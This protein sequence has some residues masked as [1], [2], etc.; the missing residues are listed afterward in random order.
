MQNTLPDEVCALYNMIHWLFSSC[1]LSRSHLLPLGLYQ[2]TCNPRSKSRPRNWKQTHER[3]RSPRYLDVNQC[4]FISISQT[5]SSHVFILQSF[6]NLS[7]SH[8]IL[9][10]TLCL[11]VVNK[12]WTFLEFLHI[13]SS[14]IKTW[15]TVINPVTRNQGPIFLAEIQVNIGQ[16]HLKILHSFSQPPGVITSPSTYTHKVAFDIRLAAGI[17]ALYC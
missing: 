16:K 17:M 4:F 11:N 1:N 12:Y 14:K 2:P 9:K 13:S 10:K 8:H 15:M 3:T 6:S 7:T 5:W